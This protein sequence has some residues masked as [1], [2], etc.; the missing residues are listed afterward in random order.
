MNFI[1]PPEQLNIIVPDGNSYDYLTDIAIDDA[2]QTIVFNAP[3]QDYDANGNNYKLNAGAIYITDRNGNNIQKVTPYEK[4]RKVDTN[5][6]VFGHHVD[7][8]GDGKVILTTARGE[9]DE[10]GAIYIVARDNGSLKWEVKKRIQPSWAIAGDKVGFSSAISDLNNGVYTIVAGAPF[11]TIN[12]F[13]ENGRASLYEYNL[14]TNTITELAIFLPSSLLASQQFAYT[15]DI[16]GDA[17][18][19]AIG[20]YGV[21]GGGYV[22]MFY[23]PPTGW[24][25]K[26]EDVTYNDGYT[27][28]GY[29]GVTNSS[30]PTTFAFK[31]LALTKTADWMAIGA[32]G[33]GANDIGKTY[34]YAKRDPT[35]GITDYTAQSIGGGDAI[36]QSDAASFYKETDGIGDWESTDV[37]TFQS[38]ATTTNNSAYA[39]EV[40]S[41]STPTAGAQI[42]L[43]LNLTNG[44]LYRITFDARH[45]GT[46]DDWLIGIG[47]SSSIY[48]GMA[49]LA[50][51]DTTFATF[52][53]TFRY[54]SQYLNLI[55]KENN[56]SNDGGIIID[57][58]R[59]EYTPEYIVNGNF[60][61]NVGNAGW[62]F[63]FGWAISNNRLVHSAGVYTDPAYQSLPDIESGTDYRIVFTVANITAGSCSCTFGSVAVQ[64]I[65]S[66][67]TYIKKVTAAADGALLT[68]TPTADFN[69]EIYDISI[70]PAT[71]DYITDH[72]DNG[73]DGDQVFTGDHD[74]GYYGS[75]VGFN[76]DADFLLIG[77]QEYDNSGDQDQG[78]VLYSVLTNG[79]WSD[80]VRFQPDDP[81]QNNFFGY[82]TAASDRHIFTIASDYSNG[83][84]LYVGAVYI[85]KYKDSL[86]ASAT[87]VEAQ[88][89]VDFQ[90]HEILPRKRA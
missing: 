15:I 70:I 68:F 43:P 28:S 51:T 80:P 12:G 54:G 26:Q 76:P 14:A 5:G 60:L 30:S 65:T 67:T 61:D 84:V 53:T 36:N 48:F 7:I 72:G 86:V 4:W 57:N 90:Y 64:T 18:V 50:N 37:D 45:V 46:G 47:S 71:N 75:A 58:I 69:G 8:S 38:Q 35:T 63:T 81:I 27:E 17:S 31:P 33:Q 22:R 13:S 41:N 44:K 52:T 82:H 19:V 24:G 39:L 10:T 42:S 83:A 55:V 62:A 88:K 77:Q 79:V 9:D 16:S 3:F 29:Y 21:Y 66:N 59:I 23:R 34:L 40:S 6:Q 74:A 56:A 49:A 73:V 25:N 32:H 1:L 89:P 2:G 20:C 87:D 11:A 78:A 85:H